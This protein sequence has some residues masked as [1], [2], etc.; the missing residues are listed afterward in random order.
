MRLFKSKQDGEK[1]DKNSW[2][3]LVIVVNDPDRFDLKRAELWLKN[4]E[5]VTLALPQDLS[6]SLSEIRGLRL[7]SIR[8]KNS[9]ADIYNRAVVESSKKWVLIIEDEEKVDLS[10]LPATR[11]THQRWMPAIIKKENDEPGFHQY[12]IRLVPGGVKNIFSG[13]Y[14]PDATEY[15][16]KREIEL[17]SSSLHIWKPETQIRKF[18]PEGELSVGPPTPRAYLVI[19]ES[20]FKNREYILAAAQYRQVLKMEKVLP[21][22][23]LAAVNG[24]AGCFTEQYK[25]EKS[26][27][28][29]EQSLQA[30]PRQWMPY[31]IKF[32]INQLQKK[33]GEAYE[34]LNQFHSLIGVDSKASFDKSI[35]EED[36]LFQLGD[37]ALKARYIKKAFSHFEEFYKF[38]DGNV[39]RDFLKRLFV[40]SAEL[41]D[42]DKTVFYFERLFAPYMPDKLSREAS[43]QLH[44]CTEFFMRKGWYDYVLT[45]YEELL[46]EQPNNSDFRRR[47]VVALS[48]TNRMERAREYITN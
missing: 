12:Q 45:T 20:Y 7:L 36:T 39:D 15:M 17:D 28:L 21:F 37:I 22:D 47:L 48:K 42:Y 29:C 1:I 46:E 23:R 34:V 40:L 33:W 14:L 32:R 19:G 11:P 16:M 5:S 3:D 41:N 18:D 9:K 31:L 2:L 13:K 26:L 38:K 24:L 43:E 10:R 27:R 25:W 44:D 35:R 4:F 30:E 8:N 6:E